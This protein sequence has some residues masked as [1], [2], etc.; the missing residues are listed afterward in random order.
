M[1]W[2]LYVVQRAYALKNGRYSVSNPLATLS[3]PP[4]SQLETERSTKESGGRRGL[5][6]PSF[7]F[8]AKISAGS[9][10]APMEK[11][12]G[13]MFPINSSTPP[14]DLMRALERMERAIAG[15]AVRTVDP[16]GDWTRPDREE[17][18]ICFL[19]LPLNDMQQSFFSCCGRYICGGCNFTQLE[20]GGEY[21]NSRTRA[22]KV[23]SCAF[24]REPVKGD[25]TAEYYVAK[26]TKY[27]N[28]GRADAMCQIGS[29][30][31]DGLM[32]MQKDASKAVIWFRRAAEANNAKGAAMLAQCFLFGHGVEKDDEQ[33]L[34]YF[35]KAAHLGEYRAFVNIGVIHWGRGDVE[36]AMLSYR[37]AAMCGVVNESLFRN[38][39]EGYQAGYITKNEYLHTLREHQSAVEGFKS[40]SRERCIQEFGEN[41]ERF[42]N[43]HYLRQV[44]AGGPRVRA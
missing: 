38:L 12:K 18:P 11:R 25:R 39:R 36:E 37:K 28:A 19:P 27:A 31:K 6:R 32:G 16:L 43:V 34:E 22:P 7:S 3:M 41:G 26:E 15:A 30:Y 44:A 17:C 33:A 40:E 42:P 20:A 5:R 1:I 14:L 13:R 29:Y 9:G 4:N 35:E 10:G 21:D 8:G 24:C 2:A 23:V